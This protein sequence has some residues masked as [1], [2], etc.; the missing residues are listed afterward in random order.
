MPVHRGSNQPKLAPTLD[1]G[2]VTNFNQSQ[3]TFNATASAINVSQT[4]IPNI[5]NA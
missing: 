2:A 3:A 5:L 1:I 4:D